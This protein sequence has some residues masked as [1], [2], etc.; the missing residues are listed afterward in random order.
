MQTLLTVSSI[1]TC[2]VSGWMAV[3]YLVLR[4]PHYEARF[5]LAALVF[6]GAATLVPGRPVGSLR[7]A[8]LVWGI[9]LMVLGV[10][11]LGSG[12][13]DGWVLIAAS[14]FIVEGL[15]AV[16]AV[17]PAD[18]PTRTLPASANARP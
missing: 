15:L 14:L 13:D 17:W 5:A 10:W 3:M 11:G 8:T 2:L 16:I 18:R 1:F 12:G 4:H 7:A 9:A 6:T